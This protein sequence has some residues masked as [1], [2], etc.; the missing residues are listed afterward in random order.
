MI[1]MTSEIILCENCSADITKDINSGN[2]ICTKC[3]RF[4]F[5]YAESSSIEDSPEE[6][7]IKGKEYPRFVFD[8]EEPPVDIDEEAP[9][10][11]FNG[12]LDD[13]FPL[14]EAPDS[15]SLCEGF[16][17]HL[18]R[19]IYSRESV[20]NGA[21]T[22]HFNS[23]K[24]FIKQLFRNGQRMIS[25]EQV[26][27]FIS[28]SN[29]VWDNNALYFKGQVLSRMNF[30]HPMEKHQ[31]HLSIVAR[32]S[33]FGIEPISFFSETNTSSENNWAIILSSTDGQSWGDRWIGSKQGFE[34]LREAEF[35]EWFSIYDDILICYTCEKS[36]NA[37]SSLLK[38]EHLPLRGTCSECSS[39]K[40]NFVDG[41]PGKVKTS[42]PIIY[43]HTRKAF[44]PS[45]VNQD[46]ELDI[47]EIWEEY[48]RTNSIDTVE[49]FPLPSGA[50]PDSLQE[51]IR[52]ELQL[53]RS[54]AELYAKLRGIPLSYP[55]HLRD[56]VEVL[57]ELRWLN[58][59]VLRLA[60]RIG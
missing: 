3:N 26:E 1:N 40:F 46:E 52:L 55:N 21:S 28:H 12:Q 42:I 47:E 43:D 8:E 44:Y 41:P 9:P 50:I 18:L 19:V 23:G 54:S 45:I 57:R 31:Y 16:I 56:G 15:S 60:E 38:D 17:Q 22:T 7:I 5:D 20:K 11:D 6:E 27:R 35:I 48:R 59:Q 32:E 25:S 2:L 30:E 37:R 39:T 14:E 4:Q 58:D 51:I 34:V 36:Y 29:Q 53:H 10:V 13:L 49:N 33:N 24:E